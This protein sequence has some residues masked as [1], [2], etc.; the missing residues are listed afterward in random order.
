MRY[1]FA[2]AV[3][4][5][6]YALALASVDPWDLGF[7]AL[8]GIGVVFG[9][10]GFLFP[11]PGVAPSKVLQRSLR[12]PRLVLATLAEIMRGTW[13]VARAVL[14]PQIPDRA[15]FVAIPNADRTPSGVI[16]SGYL[17]TLSPGS[18]LIHPDPDA[19]TWTIHAL[20]VSDPQAVIE[21][22]QEFYE[23]YQR[24]VWP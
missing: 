11:E 13:Q 23:R 6:V 12:F 24:P 14:S 19:G 2:I 4:A 7:G 1:V 21:N 15:G 3:L 22:A 8:L 9:F 20:D 17:N 16:I 10:K 18:V 5:A